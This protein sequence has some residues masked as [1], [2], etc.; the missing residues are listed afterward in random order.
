[1]CSRSD[2]VNGFEQGLFVSL[3]FFVLNL[4]S[5]KKKKQLEARCQPLIFSCKTNEEK[6]T[7]SND[8]DMLI[9]GLCECPEL[10]HGPL[11]NMSNSTCNKTNGLV[12]CL[13]CIW[14]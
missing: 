2:T 9:R 14:M 10:A 4:M 7:R 8:V 13:T 6:R 12:S 5:V 3:F 11:V 1:M